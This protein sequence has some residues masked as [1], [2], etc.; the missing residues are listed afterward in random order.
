MSN[1][2]ASKA[3]CL[4][5]VLGVADTLGATRNA[6]LPPDVTEDTIREIVI[7]YLRDNPESRHVG[8]ASQVG[9][10]LMAAFPCKK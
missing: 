10:S 7:K 1:Q 8:A 4:N 6:C 5:Y 3:A 9:I 2:P